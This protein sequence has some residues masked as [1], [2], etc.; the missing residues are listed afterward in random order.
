MRYYI[1]LTTCVLILIAAFGFGSQPPSDAAIMAIY[2]EHHDSLTQLVQLY[3][4]DQVEVIVH[5]NGSIFPSKATQQLSS[6]RLSH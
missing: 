4:E 3:Q 1:V 5:K 2:Y 6:E